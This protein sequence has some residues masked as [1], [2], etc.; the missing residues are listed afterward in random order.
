MTHT[1]VST[2]VDQALLA[3]ARALHAAPTDAALI[4]DALIALWL[5]IERRRSTPS[6]PPR[7]GCTRSTNR[8]NG[9]DLASFRDRGSG[10]VTAMPRWGELWWCE[11]PDIGRRPVVVLSRNA[12]IR[13][14]VARSSRPAR[15]R[16]ADCRAKWSSSPVTIR[17]ASQCGEPRCRRE[18]FDCGAR[19]SPRHAQR[20]PHARHLRGPRGSRSTAPDAKAGRRAG[21]SCFDQPD[22]TLTVTGCPDDERAA[23]NP[24]IHRR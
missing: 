14:C 10:D 17:W 8:T 4:D 6:T 22:G 18:R 2:T 13:G 24:E 11:L 16:S 19:R 9:G 7:T 15:P 20:H 21:R 23:G 1:R 12:A 5:G 3:Q